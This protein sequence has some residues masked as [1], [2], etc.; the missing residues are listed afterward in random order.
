MRRESIRPMETLIF[1]TIVYAWSTCTHRSPVAGYVEQLKYGV[2]HLREGKGAIY[3]KAAGN[4]WIASLASC[5]S[6]VDRN[7]KDSDDFYYGNATLF[8][9]HS[10]PYQ[11]VVAGFNSTGESAFYSVPGSTLWISAPSGYNGPQRPSILT[12]DLSGC[13]AGY[14]K[15]GRNA[16]DR[17]RVEGQEGDG[18]L[19]PGCKYAS[20]FNG[21][22]SAAPV[23]SGV[24]ALM[25]EANENLTWRDVKYILAK[26]ADQVRASIGNRDHYREDRRLDGH[27]YLPGWIT[28]AADFKFHNYFGFGGV[29]GDAA[30]T[31]AEDYTSSLGE[32]VESAWTESGTISA[33]NAI[34]DV[35]A[36][37]RTHALTV[38]HQPHHRGGSDRV[39]RHPPP[40]FRCGGGAE[41]TPRNQI[42][43]CS[44]QFQYPGEQY[45][46]LDSRQQRLLWG[47]FHGK[48][49]HQID[50]WEE[51]RKWHLDRLEDQI[52]WVLN[53]K[54]PAIQAGWGLWLE[55]YLRVW[56]Y[57]ARVRYRLTATI[58]THRPS[59]EGA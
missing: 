15:E 29:N 51:R 42:R 52:F 20:T 28:N 9:T 10:W 53:T 25:L 4:D 30:V 12:T 45:G 36:T 26:S 38:C 40:H 44:H 46:W 49:D 37:G 32:W 50:R 54:P 8:A 47:K 34:P 43:H 55:K 2:N 16:F 35:S 24:V 59:R 33:D 57:R 14:S 27:V 13:E 21:T 23:V 7:S 48:L 22:S 6:S 19:N 31:M 3:V 1:S 18:D 5:D 56:T 41:L 17:G 11:I 39:V 58:P